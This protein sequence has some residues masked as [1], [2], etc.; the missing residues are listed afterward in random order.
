MKGPC[1]QRGRR[2][3]S[4][5]VRL[6][7]CRPGG[8]R[9]GA[10]RRRRA[11]PTRLAVAA[12]VRGGSLAGHTH[13]PAEQVGAARR[14]AA[15]RKRA[16]SQ[17]KFKLLKADSGSY[18]WVAAA[19]GSNEAAGYQLS[20]GDPV[21]AIGGFNGSDP[22]PTLAQFKQYVA[23]GRSHYFIGGG[24]FEDI[25]GR[26]TQGGT[27]STSSSIRSWVS[28]N[29]TAKETVGGVT[30]YDLASVMTVDRITACSARPT[31]AVTGT[32][33]TIACGSC[34]RSRET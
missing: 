9:A 13:S 2:A 27:V 17:P 22:T 12:A 21:M 25:G 18:T 10:F 7:G 8:F 5:S 14:R 20:M 24:G 32:Y 26:A 3:A 31:G 4:A 30:I 16:I 1:R 23:A 34:C 28:S 29:F 11:A 33:P 15:Q 6:A 19:V